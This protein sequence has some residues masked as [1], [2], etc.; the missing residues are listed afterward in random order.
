MYAEF[1]SVN[2]LRG[3]NQDDMDAWQRLDQV[4]LPL[5]RSWL[6]K[7]GLA[8]SHADDVAQEALI[9]VWN[10][11]REF[12]RRREGSFRC[13]LKKITFNCLRDYCR[14]QRRHGSAFGGDDAQQMIQAL[15]DPQGDL[16]RAWDAQHDQHVLQLAMQRAKGQFSQV[17]WRA[18]QATAVE[19]QKTREVA[20]QLGLSENAVC[21]AKSRVTA[22]IRQLTQEM[23]P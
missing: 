6:Q 7:F 23:Q 19:G 14:K 8:G 3:L 1:N 5:V 10:K 4:Y 21:I 13:W 16:S 17:T 2:L 20:K 22:R 15:A 9:I 12:Q 18:F 11:L